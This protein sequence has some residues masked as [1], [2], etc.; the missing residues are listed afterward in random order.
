MCRTNWRAGDAFYL[1]SNVPHG[2]ETIEDTTVIDTFSPPRNDYLALDEKAREASW[3]KIISGGQTGVD[4]AA[5]DAALSLGMDCGGWCPEGR[6]DEN[7]IIPAYFPVQ[8]L[9]GGGYLERTVRNVQDAD[10]TVIFHPGSLQGG[11]LATAESCREQ[12]QA[13]PL[14]RCQRCFPDA[15]S[16]R[17]SGIR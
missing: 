14:D 1:A 7:G 3:M 16:A 12:K 4:R 6:R 10:G 11:T 2:V 8:E 13:V 5:L 9:P 15:S 17:T